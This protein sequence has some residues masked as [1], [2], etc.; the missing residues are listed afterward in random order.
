MD[1]SF[2]STQNSFSNAPSTPQ[3]LLREIWQKN[4]GCL[5]KACKE[6][7]NAFTIPYGILMKPLST[8]QDRMAKQLQLLRD[9]NSILAQRYLPGSLEEIG[10][11]LASYI[12][13][14]VTFTRIFSSALTDIID[15]KCKLKNEKPIKRIKIVYNTAHYP[16]RQMNLHVQVQPF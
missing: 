9:S 7:R 1:T 16:W 15:S 14:S 13:F 6:K 12:D 11:E 3:T 8:I 4:R 2:S 5:P 10:L